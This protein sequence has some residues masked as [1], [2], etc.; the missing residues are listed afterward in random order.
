MA[1]MQSIDYLAEEIADFLASSPSREQI[2]GFHPSAKVQKRARLL[3]QKN[4]DGTITKD[5]QQE[6]DQFTYAE[7]LM[8]LIKAKA[9]TKKAS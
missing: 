9:R 4:N 2:L 6:M 7:M 3:L 8:R 1:S 5:E